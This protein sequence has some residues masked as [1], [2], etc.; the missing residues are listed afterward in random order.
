MPPA[1]TPPEPALAAPEPSWGAVPVAVAERPWVAPPPIH[2]RPP[3]EPEEPDV[4]PL[5]VMERRLILAALRRVA[6]GGRDGERQHKN[7]PQT[8]GGGRAHRTQ[9]TEMLG[10]GAPRCAGAATAVTPDAT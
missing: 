7:H 4:V 3:A 6:D 9:S 5:A 2:Y 1:W 10:D 8:H